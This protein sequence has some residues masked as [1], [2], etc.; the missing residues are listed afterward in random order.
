FFEFHLKGK[1][2]NKHP[3]AWV[4]ETG[5]NQWHKHDTW[6][7]KDAKEREYYLRERGRLTDETP[8]NGKSEESYDEYISDPA[9]P[10]PFQEKIDI[11]MSA[12]YMTSDQRFAS[13][14]TDVLVYQTPV[15][16]EDLTIAG[17]I[18][19]ELYVSTTGTDS[20]WVVKV[21][22]VYPDDYPDPNPNP[23]G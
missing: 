16:E 11:G 9:K 7:P 22:D 13:R 21:L 2:E 5:T 17:P 20:D 14:R 3:K 8:A 10:V 1:G 23:S 4:F 15:L 12:D 19:V 6:P 18:E